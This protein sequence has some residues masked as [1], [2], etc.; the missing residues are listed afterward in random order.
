MKKKEKA[1][2]VRNVKWET[3]LQKM[4]HHLGFNDQKEKLWYD[5]MNMNN[6][7]LI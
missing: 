1:L 3:K 4:L 5:N 7:N 6:V 2:K